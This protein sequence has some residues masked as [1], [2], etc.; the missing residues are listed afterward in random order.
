MN[1]NFNNSIVIITGGASGIGK[2]IS[3]NFYQMGA[4]VLVLDYDDDK[5]KYINSLSD[6]KFK[7]Y[8]VDITDILQVKSAININLKCQR[9]TRRKAPLMRA[10][11]GV[12]T[13]LCQPTRSKIKKVIRQF[14][15]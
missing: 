4:T 6:N 5:V 8:F 10:S 2:S 1:I 11:T 15:I 3:D 13:L 9:I 14:H 7:A 12:T